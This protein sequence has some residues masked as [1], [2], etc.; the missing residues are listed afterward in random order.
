M[1]PIQLSYMKNLIV[2]K[3]GLARQE[4][5]FELLVENLG[6]EKQI[7]VRWV[8]EDGIWQTLPA[9]YGYPANDRYEYWHAQTSFLLKGNNSLPGNI[10]F[11]LHVRMAGQEFWANRDGQ[12]YASDADSGVML[13]D[14]IKILSIDRCLDLPHTQKICPITVVIRKSKTFAKVAIHWTT[15]H[16]HTT[17]VANCVV[18][19][20][21]WD[22]TLRS[23][24]RN[25]NRYG[26]EV[27]TCRLRTRNAARL[28]YA[29]MVEMAEQIWWDNHFGANYQTHRERLKL[30]TLNLH[31]YQEAQQQEKFATIAAAITEL[32][33][34]VVCLQEVGEPWNNGQR[35]PSLNAA[36][37]IASLLKTPYYLYTDWAHIGFDKYCEG[38]AILSRFPFTKKSSRYVSRAKNIHDI[39]ARKAVMGQISVPGMGLVNLFSV[40]LSWWRDGFR[41]QFETLRAWADHAH[42]DNVIATLLCGDF[43]AKAGA[44]GYATIVN[45]REYEDQFLEVT[46]NGLFDKIFKNHEP[47]WEQDLVSDQRID[48][49]FKRSGGL[50]HAVTAKAVFTNQTYGRVSDHEGYYLEF[51]LQ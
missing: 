43:N 35:N 33:L 16:W 26:C 34:D 23:N 10:Q 32:N 30:L 19:R 45:S 7:E 27:W 18:S 39:H 25:P 28:E 13:D 20:H 2:R 44:E 8:G 41:E 17:H 4:L 15:D 37:V 38:V 40:H 14:T 47:A 36:R 6:Y 24:A 1:A 5:Y 49:I 48:Y 31:C 22:K 29:T 11:A 50:L 51:E 46:A 12:N 21:H 42:G 9:T 3:R